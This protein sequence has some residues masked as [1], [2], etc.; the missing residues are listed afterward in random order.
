VRV[1]IAVMKHHDEKASWGGK[2]LFGLHFLIT[3]HHQRKLRQELKQDRNLEQELLQRPWIVA[4][5]LLDLHGLL[6]LL[7][8]RTPD[9][10]P[11]NGTI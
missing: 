9:H 3:V 7:S 11:S 5:Y 2:S 1:T 10:H 4:A 6:T 8:Y